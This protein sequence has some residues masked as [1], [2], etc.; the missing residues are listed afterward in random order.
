MNWRIFGQRT[1]QGTKKSVLDLTTEEKAALEDD[2]NS[3]VSANLSSMN[4]GLHIDT[5]YAYR[6]SMTAKA[7]TAAQ[8]P[9]DPIKQR[10]IMKEDLAIAKLR[11]E[12]EGLLQKMELDRLKF[13]KEIAEWKADMSEEY[14]SGQGDMSIPDMIQ[15]FSSLKDDKNTIQTAAESPRSV[16]TMPAVAAETQ[17][18]AAD[19]LV[20]LTDDQLREIIKGF[21]KKYIKIAKLMPDQIIF[22]KIAKDM[23]SVS[24][25][26]INRGIQ[27]LREEF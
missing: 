24:D 5:V 7:N 18:V 9:I 21:D 25:K 27:I 15:L 23:P 6:K 13:Q 3:G 2:K 10:E 1:T 20:D 14:G 12:N 26:S 22:D 16:S 19:P 4:T 17:E 8:V 11:L